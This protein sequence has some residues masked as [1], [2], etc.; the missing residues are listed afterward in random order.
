MGRKAIQVTQENFLD[1][2]ENIKNHYL[3]DDTTEKYD[4][5]AWVESF[6]TMLDDLL[7]DDFFGTEG[8]LDPRGDHRE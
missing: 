2:L 5:E 4:R 1:V 3:A 6:D 8:Q 7:S